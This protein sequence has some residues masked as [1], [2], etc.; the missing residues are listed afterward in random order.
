[1]RSAPTKTAPRRRIAQKRGN[2]IFT[3]IPFLRLKNGK[4]CIPRFAIVHVG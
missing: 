1:M 2:R 3:K 4:D